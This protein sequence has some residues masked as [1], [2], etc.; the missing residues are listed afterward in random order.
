[1]RIVGMARAYNTPA[2]HA[3]FIVIAAVAINLTVVLLFAL[4][5]HTWETRCHHAGG[6]VVDNKCVKGTWTTLHP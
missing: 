5:H 2:W 3:F 6:V 4:P 1:M